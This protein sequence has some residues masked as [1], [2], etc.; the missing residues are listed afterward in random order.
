LGYAALDVRLT[1]VV[2]SLRNRGWGQAKSC[3]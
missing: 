2:V 3:S 1:T